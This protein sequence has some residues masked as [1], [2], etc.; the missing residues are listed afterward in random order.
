MQVQC[1]RTVDAT[2]VSIKYIKSR[3]AVIFYLYVP[4]HLW[5]YED[6]VKCVPFNEAIP[7]L[8]ERHPK[9]LKRILEIRKSL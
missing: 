7:F 4:I 5:Y 3:D 6:A 1:T 2:V 8:A 9:A